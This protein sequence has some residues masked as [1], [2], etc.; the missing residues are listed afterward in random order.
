MKRYPPNQTRLVPGVGRPLLR[1]GGPISYEATP[2]A[3]FQPLLPEIQGQKVIILALNFSM[4]LRVRGPFCFFFNPENVLPFF[5][6]ALSSSPTARHLGLDCRICAIFARQTVY[7]PDCL[8]SQTHITLALNFSMRLRVRGPFC[9]FFKPPSDTPLSSPRLPP[10][11][12]DSGSE[13][14]VEG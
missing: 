8:D 5:S 4:R 3:V 2:S 11:L 13:F 9:F 10:W 14:R 7:V 12:R 1:V 6:E